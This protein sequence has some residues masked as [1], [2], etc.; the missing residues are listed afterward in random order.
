M[1]LRRSVE[2]R[3]E[4]LKQPTSVEQSECERLEQRTSGNTLTGQILVRLTASFCSL[5][6]K[7]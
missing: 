4:I 1:A 3:Y 7:V 6:I 5:S 2:D